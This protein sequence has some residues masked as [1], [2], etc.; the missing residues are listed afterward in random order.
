MPTV[1]LSATKLFSVWK[2]GR[3]MA[4]P[5]V[6]PW[7][8]IHLCCVIAFTVQLAMI[9]R[10][11]IRPTRTVVSSQIKE[12]S[13]LTELPVVFKVCVDT[14][15]TKAAVEAVGYQR[16]FHLFSGRSKFDGDL[17]GWSGHT[18]GG[19]TIGPHTVKGTRSAQMLC[20]TMT[21]AGLIS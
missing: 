18:S 16:K 3:C 6:R 7:L 13:Q 1:A 2:P 11:Y 20:V 8:F 5:M 4:L 9:A 10:E 14:G 21:P 17:V 19:G 12:L 15:V